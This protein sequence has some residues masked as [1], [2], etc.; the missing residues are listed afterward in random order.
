MSWFLSMTLPSVGRW[1]P[2]RTFTIVVYRR[3]FGP[4]QAK[5][6]ALVSRRSTSEQGNEASEPDRDAVRADLVGHC[7]RTAL[8]PGDH[9]PASA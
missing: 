1:N 6:L 2:L 7:T 9:R 3:R 8:H 4:D 5:Q